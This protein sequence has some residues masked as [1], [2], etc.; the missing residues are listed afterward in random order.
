MP[1][2]VPNQLQYMSSS[3]PR[4]RRAACDW[5]IPSGR[6][7]PAGGRRLDRSGRSAG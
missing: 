3:S 1:E 6:L 4:S 2:P 5:S 7:F